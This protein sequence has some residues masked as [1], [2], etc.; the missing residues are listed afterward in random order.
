MSRMVQ[1]RSGRGNEGGRVIYWPCD[2]VA[3]TDVTE[4]ALR[5][6]VKA[7]RSKSQARRATDD[8]TLTVDKAKKKKSMIHG[9]GSKGKY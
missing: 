2:M 4:R 1:E 3:S 9:E 7:I 8:I 5:L 6:Q